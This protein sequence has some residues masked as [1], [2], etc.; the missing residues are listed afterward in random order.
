MDT[1]AGLA[2]KSSSFPRELTEAHSLYVSSNILLCQHYL[3]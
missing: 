3:V 2:V 1:S